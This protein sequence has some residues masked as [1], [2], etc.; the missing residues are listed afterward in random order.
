MAHGD[1]ARW[2]ARFEERRVTAARL[3]SPLYAFLFGRL[4]TDLA[5]HGPT[6]D[7]LGPHLSEPTAAVPGLRLLAAVHRLALEGT[8]P[9]VAAHY[10]SAGG[11]APGDQ[12]TRDA[13]WAA[14]RALLRERASDL[15]PL[16]ARPCQTNEVGRSSALALG[17]LV[18]A[19]RTRL[20][21]RHL[22][23]GTSAGLNLRWDHFRHACS[24][25]RRG[26]GPRDADCRLDGLWV[27]PPPARVRSA[28]V[29]VVARAGC[30]PHPIDPT[31]E[32]GRL[33]LTA[34]V[35]PDM[36]ARHDRLRGAIAT[37][38]RVPAEVAAASADEW[39]AA[40]LAAPVPGTTTVVTSSVVWRYL[41][42][43]VRRTV[44]ATLAG[45]AA[46]ADAQA[47]VAWV[48]LEPARRAS[49]HTGEPYEVTVRMADGRRR[50]AQ[51]EVVGTA[52][53]H[54]T[55]CRWRAVDG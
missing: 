21:L 34:A 48:Q 7:L 52:L 8:A 50:W 43:A 4:A 6:H 37:A 30:D 17:L 11:R 54:G 22:E 2:I 31:T 41:D 14:V 20:P 23:I 33:A 38:R 39:L 47:P 35:W 45:A 5:A 16:V 40:M 29:E 55:D 44:E 53:A 19:A 46:R 12:A 25:G 10:P 42:D 27:D 9:D 13:C 51:V 18:V 1:L 15:A 26:F 49:H 28:P 36:A 24:H 3:G 32:D